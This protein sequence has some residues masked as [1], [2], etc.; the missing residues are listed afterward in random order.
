MNMIE[1]LASVVRETGA[2]CL[3]EFGDLEAYVLRGGGDGCV[4]VG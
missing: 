1:A 3:E 4:F 2:L